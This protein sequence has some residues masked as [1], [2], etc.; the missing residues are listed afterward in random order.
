MAK[1]IKIRF[2]DDIEMKF[3]I[4]EDAKKGDYF[5][6]LNLNDEEILKPVI[7]KLKQEIEKR[8]NRVFETQIEQRIQHAK[9]NWL[10]EYRNSEEFQNLLQI[11]NEFNNKL[12]IETM[13]VVKKVENTFNEQKNAMEKEHNDLKHEFEMFK[14]KSEYEKTKAL[15]KLKFDLRNEYEKCYSANS[16]IIGEK[17]ENWIYNN[18]ANFISPLGQN[19]HFNKITKTNSEGE[20]ADFRFFMT[21][22]PN[23]ITNE[24][25]IDVIIEA[26]SFDK[27]NVISRKKNR[28]FFNKLDRNRGNNKEIYAVL[29]T[30]LE[31]DDN[32]I[33]RRIDNYKNMF[34]LRPEA[35]TAFLGILYWLGT[36]IINNIHE[37][38][39][40]EEKETIIDK[41]NDLKNDILNKQFKYLN[42]K[43]AQIQKINSSI[44]EH[45][46][47]IVDLSD[48][49]QKQID[50]LIQNCVE[51]IKSRLQEFSTIHL[52]TKN[53]K[54]T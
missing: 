37:D 52:M 16:K 47:K 10:N 30:E 33:I 31:P 49:M 46:S 51:K 15:D 35:L 27:Q 22:K 5:S 28:D 36:W 50:Y 2:V 39:V 6:L 40:F 23:G 9:Y 54:Q 1:A 43:C 48:N 3:E 11:K 29:V 41:F 34:M 13:K 38:Y 44:R 32:F 24:T 25:V 21:K 12:E 20:K 19:V 17:L 14:Q 18:C 8:K 42:D 53:K 7:E 45:S 4:L 26:K